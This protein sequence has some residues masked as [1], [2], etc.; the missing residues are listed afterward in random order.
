MKSNILQT[1]MLV[2]VVFSIVVSQSVLISSSTS[3]TVIVSPSSV[4]VAV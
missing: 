4:A 2:A 1:F 3:N